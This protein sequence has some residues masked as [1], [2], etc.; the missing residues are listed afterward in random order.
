M[1]ATIALPVRLDKQLNN[2]RFLGAGVC[3][4]MFMELIVQA[5][6]STK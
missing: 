2:V 3:S 5:A 4:L 1:N 6:V